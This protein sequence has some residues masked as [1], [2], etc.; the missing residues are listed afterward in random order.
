MKEKMRLGFF[1]ITTLLFITSVNGQI[2]FVNPPVD[3]TVTCNNLNTFP[4][5]PETMDDC[6]GS[7]F[8]FFTDFSDRTLSTDTC[9][10][11]E[12]TLTRVF[13]ATN[14]C[15]DTTQ[16]IQIISVIDTIAPVFSPPAAVTINCDDIDNLEVAGGVASFADECG[17]PT[18]AR[19]EDDDTKPRCGSTIVRT[20]I[21]SDVCGNSS[22][23]SQEITI[24]DTTPPTY[25]DSPRDIS[26]MCRMTDNPYPIFNDW[27]QN[28]GYGTYQDACNEVDFFF[29][30]VPGS[31]DLNDPS[32]FPGE[33]PN[34]LNPPECGVIEGATQFET[35]DFVIIDDCGNPYMEQATFYYVDDVFPVLGDCEPD[36]T[37]NLT[38]NSCAANLGFEIPSAI[39]SCS[40]ENL[41]IRISDLQNI[42]SGAQGNVDSVISEMT[43]RLEGYGPEF[44]FEDSVYFDVNFMNRPWRVL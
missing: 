43:F 40:M 8:V 24:E 37:V 26:V 36:V 12:Y 1:W 33:N 19:Y 4:D 28:L 9:A 2:T 31:Y 20:W 30:A 5:T 10:F 14:N 32:T 17:G 23:A 27:V 18:F 3:T 22:T 11:Y 42:S 38:G 44:A 21:V 35:V 29:A 6:E 34:G 39:D 15:E 41:Q 25:V 13:T 7:I 16:Y